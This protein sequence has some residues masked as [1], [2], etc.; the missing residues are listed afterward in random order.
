M[1]VVEPKVVDDNVEDSI[2]DKD[3]RSV[4]SVDEE[5]NSFDTIISVVLG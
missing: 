2:S 5:D 4:F 3:V 1:F